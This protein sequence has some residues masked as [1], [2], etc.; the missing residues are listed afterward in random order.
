MVANRLHSMYTYL[1]TSIH[2]VE[3][4]RVCYLGR[5]Q[6]RTPHGTR[7]ERMCGRR[8]DQQWTDSS[9]FWARLKY[10][11]PH[12]KFCPSARALNF[13]FLPLCNHRFGPILGTSVRGSPSR[14]KVRTE[15]WDYKIGFGLEN[16]AFRPFVYNLPSST[17]S[18]PPDFHVTANGRFLLH[19]RYC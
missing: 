12:S 14:Q 17:A 13:S 5:W 10:L 15:S 3:A 4:L 2:A 18:P 6:H 16:P 8:L 9:F 1:C 7:H 19:P 11:Y